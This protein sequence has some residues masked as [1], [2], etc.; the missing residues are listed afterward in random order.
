MGQSTYKVDNLKGY[1][2]AILT[3][4]FYESQLEYLRKAFTKEKK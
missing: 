1:R 3:I 4:L 2:Q